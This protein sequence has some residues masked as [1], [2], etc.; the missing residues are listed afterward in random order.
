MYQTVVRRVHYRPCMRAGTCGLLI[1]KMIK[2]SKISII[3]PD[4]NLEKKKE[5]TQ[6]SLKSPIGLEEGNH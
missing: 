3:F 6:R 2:V 4:C 5:I 1:N